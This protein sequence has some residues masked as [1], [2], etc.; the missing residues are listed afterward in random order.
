MIRFAPSSHS[1]EKAESELSRNGYAFLVAT[2]RDDDAAADR[3][4]SQL[5]IQEATKAATFLAR[6]PRDCAAEG[7]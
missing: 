5:T 2:L 4:R 7:V 6:G 1:I 3:L